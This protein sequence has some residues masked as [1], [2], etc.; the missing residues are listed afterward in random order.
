MIWSRYNILFEREGVYLFY[1]SLSNAFAELPEE[2]YCLLTRCKAG[3]E[4]SVSNETLKDN[5]KRMKAIVNSD[6][7]EILETKYRLML[8]R[9]DNQLISLTINP[10]LGCNF[11]CPYCFEKNH[12][13]VF[14]TDE[15]E[16]GIVEF[17]R[18]KTEAKKIDITWFGGEP[19]L[20]F[21]RI[22]SLTHKLQSL[23]LKYNAGM[24]TNGYLLD[25][26]IIIKLKELAIRKIQITVDGLEEEHNRRRYLKNGEPTFDRIVKNISLLDKLAPDIRVNIRVNIDSDNMNNF[27]HIFDY[28]YQKHYTNIVVTP[29]FVEDQAGDNNCAFNSEKKFSFLTDL[30]QKYGIDFNS[31]YP[32][33]GVSECSIRNSNV[34]VIGPEGEIYKC[35]NDVGRQDRIIGDVW[36]KISNKKLLLHYLIG[37]DLY[38]DPQCKECI[39]LP[40]CSGGC[41]YKRIMWQ[42]G[43][44]DRKEV[45][46]I[47]NLDIKTHLWL[48]YL[49]K[50]KHKSTSKSY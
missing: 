25:A 47:M 12:R 14:M 36:G 23:G 7:E 43:E 38:D 44:I 40:V 27:V 1:N 24:I 5:L 2:T 46:P 8:H 22:I 16:D 15:V 28:F 48:H 18:R 13:N 20:A 31:F 3:E 30:F 10:T 39:L 6:D 29:G 4:F 45:C 26:P 17:I 34:M 49:S 35:W 21:Q 33:Y 41:P 11:A 9:F 37:A 50:K 32:S 19:L 42:A